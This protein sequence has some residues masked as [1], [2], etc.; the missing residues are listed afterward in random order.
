MYQLCTSRPSDMKW[1]P[2]APVKGSL[3]VN[4]GR[5]M[6]RITNGQWKATKHR[7]RFTKNVLPRI[8]NFAENS[9]ILTTYQLIDLVQI[10]P[11]HWSKTMGGFNDKEQANI[12]K[13]L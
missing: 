7:V 3:V 2:V 10:V 1:I 8:F 11:A 5:A 9:N 4:T 12:R 13:F 6:E